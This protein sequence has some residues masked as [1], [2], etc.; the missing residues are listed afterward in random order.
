MAGLSS[1]L[2]TSKSLVSAGDYVKYGFP[3]ASAMT[4]LAWGFL[5]FKEAYDAAWQTHFL[6]EA[7][8]WGADYF[9]KAHISR[10]QL[11]AQV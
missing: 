10:N 6:K 2:F 5:E 1:S 8:K 11:I 4:L 9:I 7:L 3:T